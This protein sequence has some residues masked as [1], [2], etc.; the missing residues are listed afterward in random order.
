VNGVSEC[1]SGASGV[2]ECNEWVSEMSGVSE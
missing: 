2:S 1:V